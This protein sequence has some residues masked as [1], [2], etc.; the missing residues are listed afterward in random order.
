[1]AEDRACARARFAAATAFGGV[2]SDRLPRGSGWHAFS[3]RWQTLE[4]LLERVHVVTD[5]NIFRLVQIFVDLIFVMVSTDENKI[6]SK[7]TG[8]TV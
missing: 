2:E 8:Y 3:R 1:M 6:Q 5:K 7:I 4:V